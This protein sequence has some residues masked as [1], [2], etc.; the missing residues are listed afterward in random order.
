MSYKKKIQLLQNWYFTYY[1]G[2][3]EEGETPV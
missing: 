1:Y 2:G 3:G